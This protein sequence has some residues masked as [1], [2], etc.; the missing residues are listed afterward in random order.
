MNEIEKRY[1]EFRATVPKP[2]PDPLAWADRNGVEKNQGPRKVTQ[3]EVEE[4]RRD[5]VREG[6][7]APKRSNADAP[8]FTCPHCGAAGFLK[9]SLFIHRCPALPLM[10]NGRKSRLDPEEVHKIAGEV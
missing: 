3:V 4:R 6:Y 10:P 8:R 7:H 9:A 2:P 1:A 5:R